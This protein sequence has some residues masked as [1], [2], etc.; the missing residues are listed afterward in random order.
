MVEVGKDSYCV[1]TLILETQSLHSTSYTT[2][3]ECQV[4]HGF[5]KTPHQ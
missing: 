3:M 4:L 5:D 1:P 2:V